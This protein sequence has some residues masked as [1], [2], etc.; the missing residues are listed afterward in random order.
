LN[1]RIAATIKVI[2]KSIMIIQNGKCIQG[3]KKTTLK[4]DL[5]V[6]GQSTIHECN[7]LF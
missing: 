7:F 4:Y 5:V 6:G 1:R 2:R 3:E